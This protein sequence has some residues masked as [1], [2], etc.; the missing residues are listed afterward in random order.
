MVVRQD[1]MMIFVAPV[2]MPLLLRRSLISGTPEVV[3]SCAV[4]AAVE[5]V[6]AGTACCPS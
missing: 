2:E 3:V 6:P 5:D 1:C 4:G